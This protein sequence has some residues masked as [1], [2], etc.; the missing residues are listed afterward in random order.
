[1]PDRGGIADRADRPGRLSVSIYIPIKDATP[2]NHFLHRARWTERGGA[3]KPARNKGFSLTAALD[4]PKDGE[5]SKTLKC[6][7]ALSDDALIRG[8]LAET[9]CRS[10]GRLVI[11]LSLLQTASGQE[12]AGLHIYLN[13]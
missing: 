7:C 5:S 12:D 6:A 2:D 11:A 8:G 3:G 9:F 13:N 4:R 10:C 1:M